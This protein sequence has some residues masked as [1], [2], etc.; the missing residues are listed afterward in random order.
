MYEQHPEATQA[1]HY[2]VLIRTDNLE[3]MLMAF[4]LTLVVPFMVLTDGTEYAHYP[5]VKD[6]DC[7]FGAC[8][9]ALAAR[10]HFAIDDFLPP[11]TPAPPIVLPPL[12]KEHTATIE[13]CIQLHAQSRPEQLEY[14]E[15]THLREERISGKEE[16][17]LRHSLQAA[18]TVARLATASGVTVP[19]TN[20]SVTHVERPGRWVAFWSQITGCRETTIVGHD[21]DTRNHEKTQSQQP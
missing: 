1:N 13:R 10:G 18:A 9:V 7:F 4:R 12:S 2:S 17:D 20:R 16:T 11:L 3:A 14:L 6:G 15:V 19:V 8:G 21:D 5:I